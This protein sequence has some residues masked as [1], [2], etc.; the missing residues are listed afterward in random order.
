MKGVNTHFNLFS[1]FSETYREAKWETSL[2]CVFLAFSAILAG[3]REMIP[4][5]KSYD[6]ENLGKCSLGGLVCHHKIWVSF[7]K[8][9][10]KNFVFN[11]KKKVSKIFENLISPEN[12]VC[13]YKT[14]KMVV[15]YLPLHPLGFH[16]VLE[17]QNL[18]MC[19]S[20]LNSTIFLG[21]LAKWSLEG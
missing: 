3:A 1:N 13:G 15:F 5:Q 4:F 6:H 14:P 19:K 16:L 18:K 10:W 7:D 17:L 9:F 12:S 20:V 11:L 8:N 21:S 2:K